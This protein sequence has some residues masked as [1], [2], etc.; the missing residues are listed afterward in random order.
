MIT[1]LVSVLLSIIYIEDTKVMYKYLTLLQ[2]TLKLNEVETRIIRYAQDL[3]ERG[4]PIHSDGLKSKFS[5]YFDNKVTSNISLSNLDFAIAELRREQEKKTLAEDLLT[6]GSK[7]GNLTQS[8]IEQKIQDIL[9]SSSFKGD[10]VPTNSLLKKDNAYEGLIAKDGLSLVVP[11]IEKYIGKA[12]KGEILSI[13]AFTGSFKTV[14]ALNIAYENAMNGHNVLYLGLEDTGDRLV[15]RLV[16]NHIA[17]TAT[18]ESEL[19]KSNDIRDD[20]LTPEQQEYYNNKHNELVSLISDNLLV[21]D[22][23]DIEYKTF[24]DMT[25][26][27]RLADTEF[28]NKTGKGLDAIIVDQLALLKYADNK[29]NQ[30]DGGVMN[31]WVSYFREQALNFLN[32]TRQVTIFLVSQINRESFSQA[33]RPKSKGQYTTTAASDSHEIERTSASMITLYKDNEIDNL[34]LVN[35]PKARYG[36]VPNKPLQVEV[37][38]EYCHFGGLPNIQDKRTLTFS[39]YT[40]EDFSLKDL[41]FTGDKKDEK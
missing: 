23:T 36:Q 33:S 4:E 31:D 6:L 14:Y 5:Y 32:S 9:K 2:T 19:I 30:Y 1:N 7:V 21:W 38:G 24:N 35:I 29:K 41:L 12:T 15:S 37:Y 16:L 10:T 26:T 27:L 13:L 18:K 17:N 34:V 28:F 20:K 11:E 40:A 3:I 25:T 22:T 8:E 39:E